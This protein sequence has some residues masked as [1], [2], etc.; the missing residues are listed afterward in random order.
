MNLPLVENT[1][2][3]I[4]V[5]GAPNSVARTDNDNKLI[6]GLVGISDLDFTPLVNPLPEDFTVQGTITTDNVISGGLDLNAFALVVSDDIDSV[7]ARTVALSHDGLN[8]EIGETVFLGSLVAGMQPS[9]PSA[10]TSA[11][12]ATQALV[13]DSTEGGKWTITED[14]KIKAVAIP[15]SHWTVNAAARTFAI[16]ADGP[17]RTLLYSYQ[18]PRLNLV[19]GY[20]QYDLPASI[21]LTAGTYRHGVTFISGQLYDANVNAMTFDPR[22]INTRPCSSVD[23]DVYPQSN[24]IDVRAW[25][26]GQL[27]ID[28]SVDISLNVGGKTHLDE[29]TVNSIN[30]LTPV[31]GLCSGTSDS[32]L[33]SGGTIG[34]LLPTSSVGSLTVT[35]NGFTVGDSFHLVCAGDIHVGDKD[36]II[37]ITLNQDGTQLA[38][39]S[40]DMEDSTNTFF[41]L[42]ADFQVRTIGATGSIVTNFDFTFNKQLLKDF[43]GSRHVQ[44]STIDTTSASALTLTAQFSGQ[45]NS[46]IQTRLFYLRKQF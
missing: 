16:Y 32:V 37:T 6:T 39:L 5:D 11:Y 18:V 43:K 30:N 15:A 8:P 12:E 20:Y 3:N 4:S 38:Q 25:Y 42:E 19:N 21:T 24:G 35:A 28:D 23:P 41:E 13:I 1:P 44:L 33:I 29:L 10:L 9:Y 14:L 31:G 7:N 45:L 2:L 40:V 17:S 26:S 22:F 36:D 27:I 34:S 46:S